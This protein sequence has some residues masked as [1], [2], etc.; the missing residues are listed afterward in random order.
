MQGNAAEQLVERVGDVTRRRDSS[1]SKGCCITSIN[2]S[3][4][5]VQV[6]S[7]RVPRPLLMLW[8]GTGFVCVFLFFV[9]CGWIWM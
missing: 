6:D 2:S 8:P 1:V 9:V 5:V 7:T 3:T 4:N